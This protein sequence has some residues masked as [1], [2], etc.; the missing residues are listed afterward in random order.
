M[1][2]QI[3]K[4]VPVPKRKFRGKYPFGEMEVGDSFL[5]PADDEGATY[6]PKYRRPR[7]AGAIRTYSA[8]HGKRFTYRRLEDNSVRVWRIE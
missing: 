5:V 2:F 3:E 1:S 7:V 8:R 6:I 4:D